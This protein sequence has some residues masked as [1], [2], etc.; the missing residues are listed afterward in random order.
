MSYESM[1]EFHDLFMAGA[2]ARLRPV[3]VAAF[4]GLSAGDLVIDLGAGTGLGTLA[5]AE[6]T[7][8]RIWALEPATTMRAVLLH[9]LAASADLAAR[10]SVLA[11]AVPA[12]L[13]DVPVPVA[14]VLATHVV[15]HL[16]ARER[17]QLF[18]WMAAHLA[19]A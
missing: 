9:R 19:P 8:A 1:A 6:S 14:G 5:L 12:A 3:V 16:S 10:V 13:Q 18:A 7:P 17:A 2:W 4:A 11:G 15:G